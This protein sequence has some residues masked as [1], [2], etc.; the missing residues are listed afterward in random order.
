MNQPLP[1]HFLF[2]LIKTISSP[3]TQLTHANLIPI[4]TPVHSVDCRAETEFLYYSVV[5]IY[6]SPEDRV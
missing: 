4:P 6:D 1:L 3:L 5:E 2:N